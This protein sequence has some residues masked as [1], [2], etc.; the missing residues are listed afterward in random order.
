MP[1]TQFLPCIDSTHSHRC[2]H[3]TPARTALNRNHLSRNKPRM[4]FVCWGQCKCVPYIDST[5]SRT[6]TDVTPG[7]TGLYRTAWAAT[8]IACSLHVG[9]MQVRDLHGLHTFSYARA[10]NT[11][12]HLSR[13]MP[14]TQFVLGSMQEH[15]L[16]FHHAF[17]H[18]HRV[19][20]ART[21]LHRAT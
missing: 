2:T 11:P 3:V 1:R 21:S 17:T 8:C 4:Q 12:P 5:Q 18:A 7:L 14:R 9:V 6:H 13:H 10:R 19:T 16:S 15:D 20:P